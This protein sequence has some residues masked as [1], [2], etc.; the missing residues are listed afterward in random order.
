MTNFS[1]A[2]DEVSRS[3]DP[4]GRS[5]RLIDIYLTVKDAVIAQGFAWEIDWQAERRLDRVQESDFLRESAW[6]VLSTGFRESVVRRFFEPLSEAFLGWHSAVLIHGSRARCKR[7]ALHV[8]SNE[9][10]VNA[11]LDIAA[12]VAE[13]GFETIRSRIKEDGVS[14]L[15]TLPYIGSVTA[16]HLAKNLGLP[17]VKPDR[18]MQRIARAAGFGSPHELCEVIVDR[19]GDPIQV[20]DVVLWRYA[21]LFSNYVATF[22]SLSKSH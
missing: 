14:F 13:C 3:L 5:S 19:V 16:F 8:F 4:T 20:V 12:I 18:H 6:T 22:A 2:A 1:H 7:A 9:R 10:K 15:Q 17:V 11:I 21:T